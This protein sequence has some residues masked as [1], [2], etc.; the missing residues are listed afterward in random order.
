M[1][2]SSAVMNKNKIK[3]IIIIINYKGTG[4][5]GRV[6]IGICLK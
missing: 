3:I 5:S 2:S 1:V 6:L 4:E